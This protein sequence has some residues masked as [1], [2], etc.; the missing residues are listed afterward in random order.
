MK[1]KIELL[2]RLKFF[3]PYKKNIF[4]LVILGLFS[5]VFF[6]VGPYLSKLYIDK[7]F[8]NKDIAVFLKLTVLGVIIFLFSTLSSFIESVVKNR[9]SLKL[10]L[11]LATKFIKKMYSLDLS[12]FQEKSTGENVYRI[13]NIDVIH[14]FIVDDLPGIL[15]D[16][17]KFTIIL[18]VS[19]FLNFK[20]T[21]TLLILSP[22]FLLKSIYI[23]K[24]TALFYAEIWKVNARL[25]TKVQESF[26]KILIIKALKLETYHRRLHVK[27]LIENIRLGL[28][29][30][31]WSIINSLS[32]TFLSKAIFG[33]ISLYG[34][35]LIIRGDLSLG[36]YTAAMIY[37]TQLGRLIQS[38]SFNFENFVNLNVF[39]KKFF[40]VMNIEPKIKNLTGAKDINYLRGEIL[41]KNVV[42]GYE[43]DRQII[44]DLNL[45]IPEKLWVGI[46]GPSGSGK[47]TL[48]NLILR[49]YEPCSGE[50]FLDKFNLR[51]IRIESLRNRIAVATQE[52]LLFD[53]SIE[54]N[55]GYGLKHI[56]KDEITEA[57]R[58]VQAYDFIEQLPERYDTLI[59]ENA[60]RLSQGFKQ[61]IALAR[62]IV[63]NP[64]L[65]ILDE[66]TSSIDSASEE[67]VL[68][69]LRL[70][71]AGR[72]TIV[73]S[74]RLVTIKDADMIYFFGPNGVVENGSHQE[75]V[76]KSQSYREFFKSQMGEYPSVR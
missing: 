30:F 22:L 13:T 27:V 37:I 18:G 38:I 33:L 31:R 25:F 49:L 43:R 17:F 1:N 16:I 46:V 74:H 66:A 21:I 26:S 73:I 3:L 63:R 5:S 72:S 40:E 71:R 57:T 14:K 45:K 39:L 36:T 29:T 44:K 28:K 64:D 7:S 19:I 6:L 76:S 9:I 67:K 52:P 23:R 51:Q 69:Q 56:S 60:C 8:L 54:E 24:K 11:N 41:F 42:F 12:F 53:F 61:R 47:T 20:L 15:V 65:L 4:Q 59:G 62:A 32:S 75:L 2:I 34:G 58:I 48:I 70:K 68:R 55:I 50:I 35:W 10:K